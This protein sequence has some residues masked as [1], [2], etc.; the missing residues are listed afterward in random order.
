MFRNRFLNGVAPTIGVPFSWSQ[1][2]DRLSYTLRGSVGLQHIEQDSTPYFPND[3]AM[4]DQLEQVSQAFAASG[5]SM[6]TRYSGQNS[7]RFDLRPQ[8]LPGAQAQLVAGVAGDPGEQGSAVCIQ[9]YQHMGLVVGGSFADHRYPQAI[10]DAAVLGGVQAQADIPRL[11][12]DTQRLAV[13]IR[14]APPRCS[15][16]AAP[17]I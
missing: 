7:H 16:P 10:E 3:S 13:I 14:C 8:Q 5:T 9:A 4:Q 11:H 2:T 17:S 6:N 1:R 12:F 15:C